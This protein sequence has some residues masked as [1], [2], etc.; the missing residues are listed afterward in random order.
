MANPLPRPTVLTALAIGPASNSAVRVIPPSVD[1][2]SGTTYTLVLS[3]DGLWKSCT[4]GSAVTLTIPPNS[5]VG[6]PLYSSVII[7]QAGAGTVTI[8]AGAGVT[9]QSAGSLV[10]TNG[11]YAVVQ[12]FQKSTDVWSLF[13]NL[14]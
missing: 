13:G 2:I 4:N 9:I 1:L 7:E 3:D 6:F 12:I 10:N 5:S 8:T 14:T 11:Q